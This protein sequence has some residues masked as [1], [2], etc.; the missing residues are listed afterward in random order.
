MFILRI[1]R[2]VRRVRE[3]IYSRK[4]FL[5]YSTDLKIT[6][7]SSCT[8][9]V[10]IE[11]RVDAPET[12][13][14]LRTRGAEYGIDAPMAA[15]IDRQLTESEVCVS[16]WV[17]GEL[18]YYGWI[19]FKQRR[20]ARRTT[21]RLPTGTAFIYRCFTRADFR[22]NHIYPAALN[23]TCRWLAEQGYQWA[24]IDHQVGNSASQAGILRIGMQPFAKYTV[25]RMIWFRWAVP[26]EALY[27]LTSHA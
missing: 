27:R 1:M 3:M 7:E 4:R 26:D 17:G 16:G 12:I 14:I 9:A 20:L 25:V 18:A 22:G 6:A 10:P 24:L 13:A 11:F 23:Y 19:Q 5:V 8:A 2:G 15:Q 21:L